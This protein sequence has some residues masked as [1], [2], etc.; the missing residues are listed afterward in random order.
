LPFLIT[1]D[2]K[3]NVTCGQVSLN[4]EKEK[5]DFSARKI[6]D[7]ILSNNS[8]YR[9]EVFN[10]L[11]EEKHNEIM[12]EESRKIVIKY[13][14]STDRVKDKI[15]QAIHKI[16]HMICETNQ[17]SALKVKKKWVYCGRKRSSEERLSYSLFERLDI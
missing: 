1:T 12:E 17:L 15:F 14:I 16:L 7:N 5:V 10:P 6:N 8:Y 13:S 3:I 2:A 4:F 11:I 9:V